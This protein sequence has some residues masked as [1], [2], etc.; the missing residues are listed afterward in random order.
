MV[1]IGK[2]ED[3]THFK[4]LIFA[5]PGN[6]KTFMLGTLN[7][8][9]RTAPALILDFEGGAQTLVGRDI[10]VARIRDWQDFEE[11]HDELEAPEAPWKSVGV[12]S[13]SEAQIGG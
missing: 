5:P 9:E 1:H 10:D 7:D 11:A 2:P 8:D 4:G 12:D 3:V 6:G 13:L